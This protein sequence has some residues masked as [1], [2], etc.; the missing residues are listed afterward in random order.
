MVEQEKMKK[1][2]EKLPY[3]TWQNVAF[4]VKNMWKWDKFLVF[5]CIAQAPLNVVLNLAWLLI[6]RCV[7]SL[8]E[9]NSDFGMFF[10]RLSVFIIIVLLLNIISNIFS[11]KIR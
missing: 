10:I 8:I 6:I 2:K 9:N 1:K 3:T 11:A 7:I 5:L 4:T